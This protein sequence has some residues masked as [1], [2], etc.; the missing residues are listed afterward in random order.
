M[1]GVDLASFGGGGEDGDHRGGGG[2]GTG[3]VS[4]LF[5]VLRF[6]GVGVSQPVTRAL[7]QN[8]AEESR[9]MSDDVT[10]IIV[11]THMHKDQ[12]VSNLSELYSQAVVVDESW[13]ISSI[14]LHNILNPTLFSPKSMAFF[15]GLIV[16]FS[17]LW[18]EDR[19]KLWFVMSH[20][21]ALCLIFL[22]SRCNLLISATNQS[23]KYTKS[24]KMS[25]RISIV[26]PDWVIA[27]LTK[28][29]L[30]PIEAYHPRLTASSPIGNSFL[31]QNRPEQI[32]IKEEPQLSIGLTSPLKDPSILDLANADKNKSAAA[33]KAN[34]KFVKANIQ[35]FHSGHGAPPA[36]ADREK[37]KEKAASLVNTAGVP[38]SKAMGT[39]PGISNS[40]KSPATPIATTE[41]VK[42]EPQQVT[43]QSNRSLNSTPVKAKRII[44]LPRK[45]PLQ[46]QYEAKPEK[47]RLCDF[48]KPNPGEFDNRVPPECCLRG[49]KFLVNDVKKFLSNEV[50]KA[51]KEFLTGNNFDCSC[52]CH[53]LSTSLINEI[54]RQGAW[55]DAEA[56][57]RIRALLDLQQL[58]ASVPQ[59]DQTEFLQNTFYSPNESSSQKSSAF[60]SS[61]FLD[62]PT[63]TQLDI[64]VDVRFPSQD[65][66]QT[67]SPLALVSDKQPFHNEKLSQ[68]LKVETALTNRE[69]KTT[70]KM[71]TR[72]SK[73]NPALN[74]LY[75]KYSSEIVIMDG[76]KIVM[77]FRKL[78]PKQDS[79]KVVS[80]E[81]CALDENGASSQE[82]ISDCL[83][84]MKT[85]GSCVEI[86]W[87]ERQL[88]GTTFVPGWYNAIVSEYKS[89][90]D[91][92]VVQDVITEPTSGTVSNSSSNIAQCY[93]IPFRQLVSENKI[94]ISS[95]SSLSSSFAEGNNKLPN[96][97]FLLGDIS[98]TS[99][100]SR[101]GVNIK[102][103]PISYYD[104]FNH[105]L[106]SNN[107]PQVTTSSTG[108]AAFN[109]QPCSSSMQTSNGGQ[110]S[111]GAFVN[112]PFDM[113]KFETRL[114]S[115]TQPR[116][117]SSDRGNIS[118]NSSSIGKAFSQ[119]NSVPLL[120]EL[121]NSNAP[122]TSQF[123][124]SNSTSTAFSNSQFQP[125]FSLENNLVQKLQ[126]QRSGSQIN[127]SDLLNQ[128]T[129]EGVMTS[130]NDSC[131][132]TNG[133][134]VASSVLLL[135][136]MQQQQ[137]AMT[138]SVCSDYF[139]ESGIE[140]TTPVST[141]Q[142]QGLL[143]VAS[144]SSSTTSGTASSLSNKVASSFINGKSDVGFKYSRLAM[145]PQTQM[146]YQRHQQQLPG[147]NCL[148]QRPLVQSISTSSLTLPSPPNSQ[149]ISPSMTANMMGS[150]PSCS[151]IGQ[152]QKQTTQYT[153]LAKVIGFDDL[154]SEDE[155]DSEKGN[156]SG[157]ENDDEFIKKNALNILDNLKMF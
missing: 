48:L 56:N 88:R 110:I 11:G 54:N 9:F 40:A 104:T 133:V 57:P 83:S 70:S 146:G 42:T 135:N 79:S 16:S 62:K 33:K 96:G 120:T 112:N 91:H 129:D 67:S 15:E 97:N 134:D 19:R 55:L 141:V 138:P 81:Q 122:Y 50:L 76:N 107:C 20:F 5:T 17:G 99:S 44:R 8:G 109:L 143:L 13:A 66:Q 89:D 77:K 25:D 137:H 111:P 136:E 128:L 108:A 100:A 102:S 94:R 130:S 85:R 90:T 123:T 114:D 148:N 39:L 121:T 139:S 69:D 6:Y 74:A 30:E 98:N 43:N 32:V 31:H 84:E 115:T 105:F 18:H 34:S 151:K 149:Q 38:C 101:H 2:G 144:N 71:K 87:D 68:E 28:G 127:Q 150:S 147:M 29:Q 125:Q 12:H 73:V 154:S 49:C 153:S 72:S 22:D 117:S 35:F 126:H 27:C 82:G 45:R 156:E 58:V 92:L 37:K 64:T 65:F 140:D 155:N 61:P 132:D 46:F 63:T 113:A 131:F 86:F 103:E 52:P 41:S 3:S 142:Q 23:L 7:T 36:L 93:K 152:M 75:S 116:F 78:K 59:N 157:V 118:Q 1:S 106:S 47:R 4:R 95:S 51:V 21:G 124:D 26:T 145:D 14:M 60:E 10:H 80:G 53:F 119:T 24:L